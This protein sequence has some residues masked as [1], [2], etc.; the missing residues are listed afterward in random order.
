MDLD[1]PL[2]ESDWRELVL[3][4]CQM[5]FVSKWL[6]RE[7]DVG[8]RGWVFS[9]VRFLFPPSPSSFRTGVVVFKEWQGVLGNGEL[10]DCYRKR[11]D[12]CFRSFPRGQTTFENIDFFTFGFRFLTT[13]SSRSRESGLG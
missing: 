10:T 11:G 7:A 9:L 8:E 2:S 1:S 5:D 4:S 13:A 3:H 12:I 6:A